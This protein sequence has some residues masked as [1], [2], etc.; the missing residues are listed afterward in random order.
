MG[1]FIIGL[2]GVLVLAG[3]ALSLELDIINAKKFF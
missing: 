1:T 2:V 3:V